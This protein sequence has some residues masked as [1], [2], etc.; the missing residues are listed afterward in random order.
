MRGRAP[1][2]AVPPLL[3]DGDERQLIVEL[4]ADHSPLTIGRQEAS[5]VALTWDA[6]VSRAHADVERIGDLWTLVDDG[7]A[8]NGTY[9]NGERVHGRRPLRD[10]DVIALGPH[11][12]HLRRAAHRRRPQHGRR[13]RA[14]RRRRSARPSAAC[15]SRCA[16]RSPPS[17]S[18]RRRRTASSPPSCA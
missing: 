1:W 15:S 2:D 9:V 3:R 16:A 6:E 13:A 7:R 17:G 11:P 4:T 8:R 14:A 12:A 10:G 18:R 5:D